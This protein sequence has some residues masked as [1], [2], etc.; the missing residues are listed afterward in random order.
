MLLGFKKNLT[1]KYYVQETYNFFPII[2]L[3]RIVNKDTLVIF[4]V[5]NVL[6]MPSNDNDFRHP[7]RAQL[8]QSITNRL[9]QKK[10]EYLDSKIICVAKHILV[11]KRI[12]KIF[13]YLKLQQ[14]P[15][16]ALTAMGTGKFGIVE[17]KEDLRIKQLNNVGISFLPLTPFKGE[18]LL[19]RLKNT[20][21]IV[22]NSNDKGIPMLKSG[23]ILTAGIDK[24]II[25]ECI[26]RQYDYYPK[27]IIF[28]DDYMGN[29]ESLKKLCINLN[30]NFYGFHYKA[31]SLIP[32][33]AID[34][35]LENVRFKILEQEC[36]W[37]DYNKLK[38]KHINHN[39]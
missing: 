19:P 16:L 3:L 29:I 7:Y 17:K 9:M 27:T 21:M 8:W 4:D 33:P 2:D 34:E 37:L 6:I 18:Q 23:I 12:I 15:T 28:V 24:G 11:E 20:N 39:N 35:H 25:L 13:D 1:N 26:L 32:L 14:I 38:Q 30:L 10:I 5:D 22:P 31:V 36:V